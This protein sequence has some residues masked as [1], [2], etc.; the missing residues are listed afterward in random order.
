MTNV[1][2][3]F[4]IDVLDVLVHFKCPLFW[5]DPTLLGNIEDGFKRD[6]EFLCLP[7][8]F[9]WN[10]WI[11]WNFYIFEDKRPELIPLCHKIM[12]QHNSYPMVYNRKTMDS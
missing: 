1:V 2:H 7:L 12:E 10:L 4:Q 8:F 11:S 5:N 3:F 6:R 9:I